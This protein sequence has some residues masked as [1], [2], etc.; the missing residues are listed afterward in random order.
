[1][2]RCRAL[3]GTFVEIELLDDDS[4]AMESAFSAMVNVEH[5][6]NFYNPQS[7]L[8]KLNRGAVSQAISVSSELL[9]VLVQVQSLF[10]RTSGV[11]DAST[12]LTDGGSVVVDSLNRTVTYERPLQLNLGGIAK[13]YAVD[14]AVRELQSA[15]VS[16][17]IVNAG[18]DLRYFGDY[19][20]M[21]WVKHPRTHAPIFPIRD[22][23]A[24]AL[25]TS[26][27]SDTISVSVGAPTCMIADALTKVVL[28]LGDDSIPILAQYDAVAFFTS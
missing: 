27:P 17:G 12:S 11:F 19:F 21:V 1:M 18:G 26:S 7:E 16:G 2:R 28:A 13:G 15:G 8:S 5:R 14:Q 6:M 22:L 24:S 25:A 10:E 20:P 23:Q 4:V 9:E 3:L